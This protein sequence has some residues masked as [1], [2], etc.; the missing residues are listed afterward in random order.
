MYNTEDKIMNGVNFWCLFVTDFI[1]KHD[2]RSGRKSHLVIISARYSELV[3]FANRNRISEP[4]PYQTFQ[5]NLTTN[6]GMTD[7]DVSYKEIDYLN[8]DSN[9]RPSSS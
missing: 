9:L 6:E 1:Y 5:N 2:C 4:V 7:E 8:C 3:K